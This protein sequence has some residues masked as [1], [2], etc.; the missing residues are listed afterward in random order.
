METTGQINHTATARTM[1]QRLPQISHQRVDIGES[2][3]PWNTYRHSYSRNLAHQRL[4]QTS[5]KTN[6]YED[7]YKKMVLRMDKKMLPHKNSNPVDP[8]GELLQ[9]SALADEGYGSG[10]LSYVGRLPPAE[11]QP[12]KMKSRVSIHSLL[13]WKRYQDEKHELF[14]SMMRKLE[15]KDIDRFRNLQMVRK[16]RKMSY[17]QSEFHENF[18]LGSTTE[19]READFRMSNTSEGDSIMDSMLDG[20]LVGG[21]PQTEDFIME[22]M[23]DEDFRKRGSQSEDFV[24]SATAD[25]DFMVGSTGGSRPLEEKRVNIKRLAG[26]MST[27]KTTKVAACRHFTKG[28]CR[29]GDACSFQHS[30]E[31]SNPDTHKVF[32]GGLPHSITPVKLLWELRQ[33]GYNVVNQPKIFRGFCPQVCLSSTIEAMKLLQQGKIMICGCTVDV[34]PYKASTKK[35]RDRQLDTNNRS[36]FLGGLPSSVTVQILKTVIEKMG[37]KVTNRPLIKAGFIPKV[38]LASVQQAQELVAK[39]TIDVTGAVVSV[40]PYVSKSSSC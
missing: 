12:W 17:A 37:M 4:A 23:Q 6:F 35:E 19:H 24:M 31:G 21:S 39:G 32:L 16:Q 14:M 34:R 26:Q 40:R 36:I 25:D 3:I 33:Q 11:P 18:R 29:Q 28:W 2:M 10:D 15:V 5:H 1:T 20:D 30:I 13:K 22:G 27:T 9:L 7:E 38:T 8:F